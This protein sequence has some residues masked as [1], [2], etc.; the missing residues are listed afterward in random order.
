MTTTMDIKQELVLKASRDKVWRALT[1]PEGWTGWFSDRVEGKFAEGETLALTFGESMVCYAKVVERN[2]QDSFAYKW[3]PGEDCAMDKYPE[4]QMTTVR[5]SLADHPEGTKLTMIES[6]FENI[7]EERRANC[8]QMNTGGWEWEL[9]ELKASVD[10]G[11]VQLVDRGEIIR[12]RIYKT[13]A[14]SLWNLVATPAGMK[15]W[16]VKDVDGEFALGEMA[17]LHFETPDGRKISGPLRVVEYREP[18]VF[19]FKSHPGDE[20]GTWDKY[21]ESEATT[22]TFTL[23]AVPGGTKLRVVESGFENIPKPRRFNAILGNAEGWSIVMGWIEQAL[24]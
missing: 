13:D 4:D 14:A 7:P 10:L 17:T 20:D 24:H 11:D 21:P 22:T 15:K 9:T 1:T 18:E 8:V 3:H 6:G 23:S 16:W 19:A 2:D 5:F 12:E